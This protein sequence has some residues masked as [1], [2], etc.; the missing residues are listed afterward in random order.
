VTDTSDLAWLHDAADLQENFEA[1]GVLKLAKAGL[2][3]SVAVDGHVGYYAWVPACGKHFGHS[4]RTAGRAIRAAY[5][6]HYGRPRHLFLSRYSE[7]GPR[8]SIPPRQYG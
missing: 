6:W 4:A 3:L 8:K 2:S 7:P 5:L 1:I